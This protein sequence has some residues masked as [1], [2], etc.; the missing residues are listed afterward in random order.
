MSIL[1]KFTA[2][3]LLLILSACASKQNIVHVVPRHKH[4]YI[5]ADDTIQKVKVGEYIFREADLSILDGIELLTLVTAKSTS[6]LS[7]NFV[8]Y[9]N[10][11]LVKSYS[12]GKYYYYIAK[13]KKGFKDYMVNAVSQ[14]A[15]G[16]RRLDYAGIKQLANTNQMELF[17]VAQEREYVYPFPEAVKWK[18][19]Q[20][21]AQE[22]AGSE[23]SLIYLGKRNGQLAF[24]HKKYSNTTSRK[25]IFASKNKS[26]NTEKIIEIS[27][28]Q[29]IF[30]LDGKRIEI[31]DANSAMIAFKLGVDHQD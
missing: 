2:F 3:F 6:L 13:T 14:G 11:V 17:S 27:E 20:L 5:S 1:K 15:T 9:P 31:I 19:V 16:L 8:L 24:G 10:T 12:K 22:Y 25:S 23:N 21:H 28:I 29:K 18:K 4:Y 30:T 7:P 26:E